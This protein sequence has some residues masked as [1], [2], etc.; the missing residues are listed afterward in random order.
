MP[1]KIRR[2]SFFLY[3]FYASDVQ[4]EA[5]PELEATAAETSRAKPVYKK[6]RFQIQ[7]FGMNEKGQSCSIKITDYKPFFY[8]QV[9]IQWTQVDADSFL[10]HL[11]THI[12]KHRSA[13]LSIDLHACRNL[14]KFEHGAPDKF[15]RI[16]FESERAFQQTR[17]LWMSTTKSASGESTTKVMPYSYR[18]HKTTIFESGLPPLLRFFH[19]HKVSPSG[20]IEISAP[21]MYSKK[22]WCDHEFECSTR[23]IRPLPHKHA[24]VPL[25][26][27]SM[28]IEADSS[29]GAFPMPKKT[30]KH[31]ASQ[32]MDEFVRNQAQ[33]RTQLAVERFLLKA[34]MAVF[35]YVKL[36]SIQCVYPKSP[37]SKEKIQTVMKSIFE[38]T[39]TP[40]DTGLMKLFCQIHKDGSV[41]GDEDL[42]NN[43][44]NINENE[45]GDENE[46]DYEIDSYEDETIQ[47]PD[48]YDSRPIVNQ[49][50]DPQRTYAQNS[51]NLAFLLQTHFPPLYG[52]H[53][54]Y[55][56]FSMMRWGEK[57][58]FYNGCITS[59]ECDEV[60]GVDLI[61]VADET[62][63]LLEWQRQITR[64]RPSIM[65]GYNIFGFDYEFLFQRSLELNC[66]EEFL[67]MSANIDE[68]SYNVNYSTQEID[69]ISTSLSIASGEYTLRYYK[70]PGIIQLDMMMYLKK[71]FQYASYTLDDVSST[72]IKDEVAYTRNPGN[73]TT[74]IY[75]KNVT[76]LHASD[77][78]HILLPGVINEYHEERGTTKFQ[79][80]AMEED[81]MYP[82][83][84]NKKDVNKKKYT[85]LIFRP[86]L[87]SALTELR[88]LEW[89]MAK[90]DMP[91]PE[92][93]RMMKG[94][95]SERALIA[96]YCVQD[97]KLPLY[98]L[99]KTD[100]LTGFFQM[101]DICK[102]SLSYLIFR[103]QS[104]KTFSFMANECGPMRTECGKMEVRIPDLTKS[105]RGDR[106]E[107]A[108]VLVPKTKLYLDD[109]VGVGDFSSLYP[110]LIISNNYAHGS[111]IWTKDFDLD[112]NVCGETGERDS[113]GMY[114]YDNMPGYE[115]INTTFDRF[116]MKKDPAFP[117]RKARKTIVGTRVCRWAQF[118][119][120]QRAILPTVLAQL[121]AKRAATKKEMK[122]ESDPFMKN[123]LDKRQNGYKLTAN[124]LYGQCG[125]TVSSFYE[126]D[127]AASTTASGRLMIMY[128][129]TMAETIYGGGRRV[130]TI[131]EGVVITDAK[132]VYGDTDSV[133]FCFNLKDGVTNEPIHGKRALKI[134]IELSK[135]LTRL[136]TMWLKDPMGFAYEKTM[137]PLIMAT[138]KRYAGLLYE[139]DV[140]KYKELK[141]MGLAIKRRDSCDYTKEVFWAMLTRLMNS[142]Y[143]GS[144]DDIKRFL[145]YLLE[146]KVPTDKL[147]ITKA[148][149]GYYVKPESIAHKVLAD[150]IG[151]RDP[152]NRPKPGDRMKFIH[153][154]VPEKRGVK[155]LQGDKIETVGYML[156][157]KIPVDYNYYITNQIL[158]PISQIMA[159]GIEL[160]LSPSD[161]TAYQ[162]FIRNLEARCDPMDVDENLALF[163]SAKE[164]YCI[165]L[166]KKY[167][168]SDALNSIYLKANKL[169]PIT[170]F[171]HK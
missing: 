73:G 121:L 140:N 119:N 6:D 22:T 63:I 124:S 90:D 143:R 45:G 171:F 84:V 132:Y 99:N 83:D 95:A 133:F 54:T 125:G 96:K 106:Y 26:I 137:F 144:V 116:I 114:V 75:T 17:K 92:M 12:P 42:A 64:F 86:E 58:P 141:I 40:V 89:G 4:V 1:V 166:V 30:Y 21:S 65:I 13:I 16:V 169:T 81:V 157:K 158:N 155:L 23:Q 161:K 78:V 57:E 67:K 24:Q 35:Q 154:V 152:G 50:L 91:I 20:W 107:G 103:G 127:I 55:I 164:K 128:S 31:V 29:H 71:E 44:P 10:H 5:E 27:M 43:D 142:D 3:D 9:P 32:I 149:R 118:P 117:T 56:G 8:V 126:P 150:R 110:S 104:I 47:L 122:K 123:I 85:K 145:R 68:P 136:C 163:N 2:P 115:Y 38:S 19:I 60:E 62:D 15:A 160:I 97:C 52:D 25:T 162:S 130:T 102:V 41:P 167:I 100:V 46:Y 36:G 87:S 61:R 37:V 165:Q 151:V 53:A 134:T 146:E 139:D 39:I 14:Y 66:A 94:T 33:F 28:D 70:T 168:F 147:T 74:E 59:G 148:L 48:D 7:M 77:F 113:N 109:P 108:V 156:E 98:I 129:R 79:V 88:G 80:S 170:S 69:I 18:G 49:L 105:R 82:E 34:V 111:K 11:Q 120:G 51:C 112:G 159:L 153:V 131:D 101:A 138:K 76:G 135:E 72:L 93:Q